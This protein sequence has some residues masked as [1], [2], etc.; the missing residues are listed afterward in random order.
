MSLNG[1]KQQLGLFHVELGRVFSGLLEGLLGGLVVTTKR[2]KNWAFS[3]FL[4]ASRTSGLDPPANPSLPGVI[5]MPKLV[6]SGASS[7]PSSF[8]RSLSPFLPSAWLSG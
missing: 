8:C 6:S 3:N 7:K 5:R 4:K 2:K 1:L